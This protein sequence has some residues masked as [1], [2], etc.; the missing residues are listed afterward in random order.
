MKIWIF[1][2]L[3]LVI[4]LFCANQACGQ[5]RG[6]FSQWETL[7]RTPSVSGYEG[8]L[9]AEIKAS[10]KGL[11]P[12]TDNLGNVFVTI[13]SG[14]PHRMVATPMDQPGY[15][16][17]EITDD[18][19]LRVQRLPQRPPNEIFDLLH[20]A[21]PVVIQTRKGRSVAGVFAGLSVHLQP[22]RQNAPRMDHPDEI[23]VDIGAGSAAEVRAS[24]VDLLDPVS[25]ILND[26]ELANNQYTASAIGD[27]FGVVALVE[28]L[29][30]INVETP[31]IKGTL[32]VAFVTEQWT[33]G[34]GLDRIVNELSPAELIYVGRLRPAKDADQAQT[35]EPGEG[36]LIAGAEKEGT[37]GLAQELAAIAKIKGLKFRQMRAEP[38]RIAGY[39][40]PTSL[41]T[42]MAQLGVPTRFAV[43]PAETLSFRDIGV[44]ENLLH[45]YIT[46]KES[47]KGNGG[48]I[49]GVCGDCGPPVVGIL[50]NTYG[51][52]RHEEAVREKVKELLPEW[53][54]KKVT[55]DAAGNLVLHV[56]DESRNP[57]T[58]RIAFVAHM[59]EIGY[60][61]TK[62]EDDGRLQVEVLGGGYTQYFLGHAVFV[63]SKNRHIAGVL[64]LPAGWDKTGFAWPNGAKSMD[65]PAH[66]YVG[67]RSKEETGKLGI[68]SGD[69]V[70]IPKEYRP[71]QG[72]R[73]TARSFDDR[74]GCAALISAVK[75]LGPSLAGRDVT[76]VWSTR[77]E[78]GLEGAAAFAEQTAKEGRVPDFV[79]AIDTFVSSDSP[80]ESKRFGNTE[81]GKGFAVRAVDNSNVTPLKYVDRVVALAKENGIAVQYGVT[82]GGNDGAVFLKYG[83]VDIPLGWP[84]RYAHSPGEVID[85]KDLNALG[86]IVEVIARQ[87]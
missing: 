58:S 62:I 57:K 50:T 85:T 21:Q 56:G 28:L 76:F 40:A 46:G 18:G 2:A 71:L 47:S 78:L 14:E 6:E 52:S 4:S 24:G 22:F 34:R 80:L 64:E 3:I 72:T 68:A 77:E 15:V 81:L 30:S 75:A 32:T 53:A 54:R 87:W 74:V 63:H 33:G 17:S 23:Y 39:A 84:L 16:V 83:S 38:P 26:F 12:R 19:Y 1:P 61:V 25:L 31:Q 13:G 79:F 82:G 29:R 43:T 70:T 65:E 49:G 86:K 9:A 67:T 36:V 66:V 11:S 35:P 51:A 20:A 44:L 7:V 60:E 27:H 10:L 73:A 42:R 59:D 55:T 8:N 5:Q 37:S 41:P 69:F 45:S 48:T